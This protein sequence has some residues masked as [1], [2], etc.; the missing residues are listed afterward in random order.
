MPTPE[1]SRAALR[2]RMKLWNQGEVDSAAGTTLED[3][4]TNPDATAALKTIVEQTG[5]L[6]RDDRRH[7]AELRNRAN[8]LD[9]I[10]S[11]LNHKITDDDME[12][13]PISMSQLCRVIYHLARVADD[14]DKNAAYLARR[15]ELHELLQA[16]TK[17][18][19]PPAQEGRTR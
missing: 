8:K 18:L 1:D 17:E 13:V 6:A 4:L 2:E 3:V 7:A 14:L 19:A 11:G 5:A 10:A 12:E 16:S 15:A 9:D